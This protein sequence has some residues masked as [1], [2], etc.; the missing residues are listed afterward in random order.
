MTQD[1]NLCKETLDKFCRHNILLTLQ[2]TNVTGVIQE[3]HPKYTQDPKI[4]RLKTV[5]LPYC[6]E[7]AV[8]A[9]LPNTGICLEM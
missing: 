3:W 7:L 4:T 2:S 1:A 5:S 8:S 6:E 9:D